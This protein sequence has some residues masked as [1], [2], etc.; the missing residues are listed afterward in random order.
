[1]STRLTD[2]ELRAVLAR[3]EAIQGSTR[4]TS[5]SKAPSGENED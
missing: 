2:D 3:A 4:L 1:M 5:V